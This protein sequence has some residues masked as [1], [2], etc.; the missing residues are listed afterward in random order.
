MFLAG[1]MLFTLA[2][3]LGAWPGVGTGIVLMTTSVLT[4]GLSHRAETVSPE[5]FG[6]FVN[7]LRQLFVEQWVEFPRFVLSG[8][9]ATA[10]HQTRKKRLLHESR[11]S[12]APV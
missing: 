5:P 7:A 3:P 4:Q 9:W 2:L 10:M 12:G 1:T 6:S 8:E 11:H